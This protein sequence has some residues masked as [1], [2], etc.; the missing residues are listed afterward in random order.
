MGEKLKDISRNE[1]FEEEKQSIHSNIIVNHEWRLQM[2]A[3]LKLAVILI[4]VG[5]Q[6]Y[7]LKALLNKSEKG[8]NPV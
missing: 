6:L 2:F 8:Y 7:L 1:L 5:A 3:I 4:V